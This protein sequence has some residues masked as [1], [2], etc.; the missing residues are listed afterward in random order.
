MRVGSDW[1]QATSPSDA[2]LITAVRTGDR[3]AFGE[4]Y[5][6]HVAAAT[7]L[8]RQFAR[9]ASEADDLV[10]ESF[11]KVLD[12]LL[13][14]RGPDTAF[15]AYLFTTLRHTAYDRSRKDKRLQFTDEIESHDVA[16]EGD[17]PVL[18]DLEN[19]LVAA[20]FRTLPERWQTVLWHT[21]V[22]GQSPAEVGL[23]MGM[24]PNAV[25]S[26]AF[27]AKEGLREAY[28]QAHLADT[29]A[30]GCQTT[31]NRLGAW[32]RGGLSKREKAQVDAHLDECDR[33]RA[34]AVE[35]TEINTGLRGLLA[36]LLLGGAAAGYLATLG[37]VAPLAPIGAMVAAPAAA[38]GTTA[39][40]GTASGGSGMFSGL[41]AV[42]GKTWA[43]RAGLGTAAAGVVALATVLVI[44]LT[45]GTPSAQIPPPSAVVATT[46]VTSPPA[47]EPAVPSQPAVPTQPAPP[48]PPATVPAVIPRTTANNP[49][50][51]PTPPTT[52]DLAPTTPT[53]PTTSSSRPTTSAPV[54]TPTTT[55][56]PTTPR[57]TPTTPTTATT[58]TTPAPPAKLSAG[59]A[60][61]SPLTVGGST[62]VRLQ[63]NNDGGTASTPGQLLTV[64]APNGVSVLSYR[65]TPTGSALRSAAGMAL[66]LAAA[67]CQASGGVISCPLPAIPPGGGLNVEVELEVA[68]TVPVGAV[69]A[70]GLSGGS[71]VLGQLAVPTTGGYS[72]AELTATDPQWADQSIPANS[73]V[74]LQLT[75]W[76]DKG[77]SPGPIR[78]PIDLSG[79]LRIDVDQLPAGCTVGTDADRG[80]AVCRPDGTSPLT[81]GFQVNTGAAGPVQP[82]LL[83]LDGGR[84][85]ALTSVPVIVAVPTIDSVTL[86]GTLHAGRN[87]T[88]TVT[89]AAAD[90]LPTSG[91]L[92]LPRW[93][94]GDQVYLLPGDGCTASGQLLRCPLAGHSQWTVPA[95]ALPTADPGTTPTSGSAQFGTGTV[96]LSG[97][98]SIL[99]RAPGDPIDITGPFGGTIVG[100]ATLYCPS[101]LGSMPSR[102][103][104]PTLIPTPATV[105]TLTGPGSDAA[106]PA[107]ARIVS[108][109]FT[110][111]VGSTSGDPDVAQVSWSGQPSTITRDQDRSYAVSGTEISRADITA[112]LQQRLDDDPALSLRVDQLPASTFGGARGPLAAWSLS[113]IWT[114]PGT[115]DA[116]AH[117]AGDATTDLSGPGT[118]QLMPPVTEIAT[119]H[120]VIWGADPTIGAHKSLTAGT[121][122]WS[123]DPTDPDSPLIGFAPSLPGNTGLDLLS[124]TDLGSGPVVY[125]TDGL[126][127]TWIGPTLVIGTS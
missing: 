77:I 4:L 107:G 50:P 84:R 126:E 11:A 68:S 25:S 8:S 23:L 121:A 12:G 108:A 56:T 75:A 102:S 106:I 69:I 91:T 109:E 2:E 63:V 95:A 99:A 127:G 40:A 29:A 39:A 81:A 45:G 83:R 110:W 92:D 70:V 73:T 47:T 51:T 13:D 117:L 122:Q 125:T 88:I 42:P 120:Q 3:V 36:P 32:T 57:T 116:A 96:A 20:A 41:S 71:A 34:L 7:T 15:R 112:E 80:T 6:R 22:E 14:G 105:T 31:V 35:L 123:A 97:G 37:P 115:P 103:G 118:H 90:G 10:S 89:A 55:T 28:L 16:V 21:Q 9:S 38:A 62:L 18:A 67:P 30:Q 33:C 66:T 119:F 54:T 65:T 101:I 52:P 111:A 53:T 17:D 58:T 98:P 26:L 27:R 59:A 86:A 60:S 94:S 19:G 93:I 104:C 43:I 79:R 1:D 48:A 49:T 46:P 82:E 64:R 24:A 74:T 78:V 124:G 76:F 114:T 61:F 113:V 5:Q 85:L 44:N 87:G 72:R 100:G